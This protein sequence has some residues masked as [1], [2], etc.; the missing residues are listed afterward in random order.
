MIQG[1]FIRKIIAITALAGL[2]GACTTTYKTRE[3]SHKEITL[4]RQE[5]AP[6]TDSELLSVRI[7]AFDT[8]KLPEDP[9]WAKGLSEEIRNAESYYLAVQLRNTM[10][11]SGHWG[12]V[13]VVPKGTREGEVTVNGR[14]LESDG[15][16]LKLEISAKDA[17]GLRWFTKTYESVI[18]EKVYSTAEQQDIDPFL[19]LYAK[20]ANDIAKYK[21]KFTGKDSL[22]IRQVSELRFGADFA[23]NVFNNYIKKGP[24]EKTLPDQD[25][26]LR[27]VISFLEGSQN[28]SKTEP[29]YTIERLPPEKDPI[30]QRVSRIRAREE[31]LVDTLDQQYDGLA[32]NISDTYTQ[33][34]FSRLKEIN[35]IRESDRL[36]NEKQGE[37]IAIGI[38]GLLAG[39]AMSSNKNCY[40]CGSTGVIIAGAAVAYAVRHAVQAAEQAEADTKMRKIA[41]E[42]LGQSLT[43]EVR[44]VVIEVEGETVELTGTVEEKFQKWREALKQLRERELGPVSTSPAM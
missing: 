6:I 17:T 16:I 15:E 5:G 13:V 31:L 41:L 9:N 43:S 20:I 28:E 26:T 8:G 36:K 29:F 21:K 42:E 4:D 27:Q 40:S 19:Y 32:R 7:E 3:L 34:R 30:I 35:A 24:Y 12:P 14:I 22:T 44:P 37:A 23:P 1:S 33:W 2:L 39:A 11:R 38:L 18:N 25:D 10:Q